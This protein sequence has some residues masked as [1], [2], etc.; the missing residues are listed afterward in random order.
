[1]KHHHHKRKRKFQNTRDRRRKSI[2]TP[3]LQADV[4]PECGYNGLD[5]GDSGLQDDSYIYEWT[6]PNCGLTGKECHGLAFD[7]HIVDVAQ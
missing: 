1:M 3:K 4:C 5:Y 7:E 6:C 2:R